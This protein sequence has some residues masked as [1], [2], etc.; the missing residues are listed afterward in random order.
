MTA[1]DTVSTLLE[2]LS[3]GDFSPEVLDELRKLGRDPAQLDRILEG[4]RERGLLDQAAATNP[5]QPPEHYYVDKPG[6]F[7]LRWPLR[8]Q[9]GIPFQTLDR[10]TQFLVLF[11]EWAQRELDGIQAR[12]AGDLTGAETVFNECLERARQLDVDELV[13]RSY[14]ELMRV[15][16][17]AGDNEG[18]ER[19]SNQARAVRARSER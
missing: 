19:W 5:M 16:E 10:K 4:L 12:D 9:I 1:T 13:A 3:H 8:E 2:R 17:Q 6:R 15:A 7:D 14:E 18:A 11:N